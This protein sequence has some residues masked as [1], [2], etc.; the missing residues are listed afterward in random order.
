M[1]I[2]G[3]FSL[4]RQE[5]TINQFGNINFQFTQGIGDAVVLFKYHILK[6][7][8]PQDLYTSWQVGLGPKIPLGS[9]DKTNDIGITLNADLQPGSGAWDGVFWSNFARQ[10]S[11]RPTLMFAATTTYSFKGNNN[12]YLGSQV[13]GFGDEF[14]LIAGFSDRF[15]LGKMIIDPSLSLRYRLAMEDK[16][17]GIILANTGGQ[18]IFVVPR[19]TYV[20]RENMTW[21]INTELPIYAKITGTQLSPTYRFNTGIYYKF[22]KNKTENIPIIQF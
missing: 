12:D 4:V 20:I 3:F 2:D 10:S 7:D 15:V 14:Q 5:R 19:L 17:N 16:N 9:S 11:M 13:Y 18:W 22:S 1:A 8:S 6:K 21:H